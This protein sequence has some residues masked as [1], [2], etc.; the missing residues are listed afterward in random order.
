MATV[1]TKQVIHGMCLDFIYTI[2]DD[3]FKYDLRKILSMNA[4]LKLNNNYL[5]TSFLYKGILYKSDVDKHED[6]ANKALDSSLFNLM[7]DY[8]EQC[9]EYTVMKA[10]VGSYITR[11]LNHCRNIQD[12][13]N[14]LPV[15]IIPNLNF[16]QFE[17]IGFSHPDVL[18]KEKI[19]AIHN[20]AINQAGLAS[21]KESILLNKVLLKL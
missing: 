3:H 20:Q 6:K 15:L 7:E 21:L 2:Q 14:L 19:E 10:R 11:L 8:L 5:Q 16:L 17:E 12:V 1:L 13:Y 18:P 4:R 9:R